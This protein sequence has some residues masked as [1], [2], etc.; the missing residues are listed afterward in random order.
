MPLQKG[1]VLLDKAFGVSGLLGGVAVV[2]GAE[3]P[4]T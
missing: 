4:R 1:G 2:S 3:R